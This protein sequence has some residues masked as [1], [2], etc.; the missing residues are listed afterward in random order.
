MANHIFQKKGESTWYVRLDIPKDVQL[1]FDNRKVLIQ[2]LKTGLRSVALERRHIWLAKWKADITAARDKKLSERDQWK[3]EIQDLTQRNQSNKEKWLPTLFMPRSKDATSPPPDILA[4]TESIAPILQELYDGGMEGPV[5]AFI[6]TYHEYL[7]GLSEKLTPGQSA[8]LGAKIADAFTKL[9]MEITAE[10]YDLSE[11][12]REDMHDLASDPQSYKPKSPITPARVQKLRNY[13][14]K[15]GKDPKTIDTLVKRVELFSAYVRQQGLPI[16]FD[17]VSVYLDQLTD[18]KGI[19]LTSKTKRQHVWA[20]NTFWKWAMKYDPDWRQQYKGQA[21]PFDKHDLP[22]IK[23]ESVS[24]SVFSREEVECLQHAAMD[25]GDRPLADLI[26]LAA[27]TG[28]RLE[29]V[30]RIHRDTIT[31]EDSIPTSFKILE[32]KTE[33]GVR[34]V[35]IHSALAP[36]VLALLN[37]STDGYLLAGRSL[38]E[39]NRYGNRLDALGKRFGRLKTALGFDKTFVLHSIRK[40]AITEVH[41]AKADISVMPALFGHETGMITFDLY[42]AGPSLV[43]KRE[44]IELLN[45]DFKK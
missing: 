8:D 39:N 7:E 34:E 28:A 18:S 5:K 41:Q 33:A 32:S 1:A 38:G 17:L 2:S 40:T 14:E 13:L 19:P 37:N 16:S 35:P 22:V 45:Y 24:W 25:K 31:F 15:M 23:G 43:Q 12:E 44:V 11:D 3:E 20:G 30:G 9:H 21:S 4:Y 26:T 10:Y 29:E 6:A 42:S 27:Y 36:L